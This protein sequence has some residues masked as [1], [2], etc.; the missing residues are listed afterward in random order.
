MSRT[1]LSRYDN[2]WYDPGAG[3]IKRMLWYYCNTFFFIPSWNVSGGLKKLLLRLFGAK[4][5]KGVVIKPRTNIKYPWRLSIGDYVWIGENAWI[6]NLA[7][8][9]IGDHV[10]ISQGAYLLT[11][12]HNYKK[13][14]F[15]LMVEGITLEEGVWVGA[16][17][18]VC[19]GVTCHSHA[20]LAVNSVA[21]G[22]LEAYTI[23]QGNPAVKQKEREIGE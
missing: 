6:D 16:H 10:C 19:P 18:V 5:G 4:V 17:A 1:D 13:V 7:D 11:G 3:F 8:V 22:D 14:A 21:V 12:N 23:Y 9:H 15:D 20:V 2:R